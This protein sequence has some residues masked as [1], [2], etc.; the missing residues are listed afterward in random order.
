MN[1]KFKVLGE[2]LGKSPFLVTK[3][4]VNQPERLNFS[5]SKWK[6][7]HFFYSLKKKMTLVASQAITI[8]QSTI[9]KG[10]FVII[11]QWQSGTFHEGDV[12]VFVHC[13]FYSVH[14]TIQWVPFMGTGV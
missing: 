3:V 12:F 6:K 4:T 1:F 2:I 9:W 14:N 7:A 11:I 13:D 5:Q 8:R 10:S